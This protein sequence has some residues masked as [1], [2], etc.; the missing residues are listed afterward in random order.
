MTFIDLV[1]AINGFTLAMNLVI[2]GYALA[3]WSRK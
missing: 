2:V 1:V 3:E